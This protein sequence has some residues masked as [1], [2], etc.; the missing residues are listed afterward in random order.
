MNTRG[1]I[2]TI[3][4]AHDLFVQVLQLCQQAGLVKLGHVA[5]HGTK[6]NANA[7]KHKAMSYGRMNQE[8]ARLEG[9]VEQ[10]MAQAE[11]VNS[12]EDALYG[13]GNRGDELPEELR[14][15]EQRL[16]R[17]RQAKAVLEAQARQQQGEADDKEENRLPEATG[18]PPPEP[19]DRAQ[20]NFTDPDSRMQQLTIKRK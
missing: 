8:I 3:K 20:R 6:V 15:R 14:H 13:A 10:L 19:G 2:V 1:D 7:S 16:A 18:Q 17:I 12:E 4:V 11:A 9:A 5:L